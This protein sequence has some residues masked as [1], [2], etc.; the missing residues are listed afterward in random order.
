MDLERYPYP[1]GRRVVLGTRAALAASHPLAVAAGARVLARGGNA[2]DAALAMAAALTVLE[3][4]ANGLGGDLF[5]LVE[6][7]GRLFGL[8]ASGK[9]PRR[10]VPVAGDRIPPF[11]WAA[12]TVPG[13]VS[14]W[15]A[16]WRRFGRLPFAEVL[17]PAIAYAREGHPVAPEVARAWRRAEAVYLG[18][19]GPEFAAFKRVFFPGGRAPAAGEVW[20]SE[21]HAETLEAIAESEGEAFYRG[22]LAERIV[23]FARATGGTL[24]EEDLAGHAP[25]WVEPLSVGYRGA[26]VY[27]LPPNGQGVVALLALKVLEAFD[28]PAG[29][30]EAG[31]HRAVEATKAAFARAFAHVADPEA[32]PGVGAGLLEADA[33]LELRAAIGERAGPWPEPALVPGG[34]V[35]LAAA[36]RERSVSLIQSN[37]RGFGA[38][39]LVPGTGI[40]LHNRG[41]GFVLAPDHPNRRA[42]GRRPYHTII[43]GFL[44][45]PG[46][47]RGPFGLM[48]GF[49]QPQ[50]HLQLVLRMV[51][52]GLNPQAALDAP[53]W[54]LAFAPREL[55]LEPGYDPALARTLAERG[56]RVRIE[57]EYAVF[58]RGQI[59]LRRE[60]VLLAASE[61]RA[62]GL[63]LAL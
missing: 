12:V 13:A 60:G 25:L 49:M 55:W 14:G 53:R 52:E 58:G 24:S 22:D 18:L 45:L 43:P 41:L 57:P 38:G 34:T 54:Q 7:G 30:T 11:G 15:A 2:V 51:D 59:V 48:G 8:N 47:W 33:V 26:R 44:E 63:A 27:E 31:L 29:P 50:G 19:R 23:A 61:P 32:H 39:L 37:Y 21:G 42:P 36:D 62:D 46:G 28:L 10:L 40:A 6:E 5:A 9:S 16:L 3:P 17:A 4:T 1:S 35:Y 20:R 56:H